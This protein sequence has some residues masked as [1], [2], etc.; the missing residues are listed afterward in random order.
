MAKVTIITPDSAVYVDNYWISEMDVSSVASN[1]HAIQWDG[2]N[3]HIEYN[4]G[5]KNEEITDISPYQSIIDDHATKKAEQEAANQAEVDAQIALEAKYESKRAHEY[6]SVGDQL[7]AL[8]HAGTFD[9]TMTATL[10]AVKD[11]YPKS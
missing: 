4:D 9:A 2:S 10:Q 5:K 1:I 11:K 6:P 8:F 7:D 3:G